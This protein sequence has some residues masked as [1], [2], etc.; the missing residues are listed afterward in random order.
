MAN[1]LKKLVAQ[2]IE[3]MARQELAEAQHAEVLDAI[4]R[5]M[6][7]TNEAIAICV[8]A[9]TI[10]PT[11]KRRATKNTRRPDHDAI[12]KKYADFDPA[13]SGCLCGCGEHVA[14]GTNFVKGHHKS[15]ES[16]ARAAHAGKMSPDKMSLPGFK[17]AV[18]KEWIAED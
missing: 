7:A 17:Y 13:A 6:T 9:P 8:S 11:P 5:D 2:R 12:A 10:K 16:I 15:L 1:E 14:E 4:G 18:S 3:I